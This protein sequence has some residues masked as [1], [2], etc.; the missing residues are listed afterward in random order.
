[1]NIMSNKNL[2]LVPNAQKWV[3]YYA[4]QAEQSKRIY[5]ERENIHENNSKEKTTP[6][7][8]VTWMV[9]PSKQAVRQA[10]NEDKR[11]KKRYK[12]EVD[13]L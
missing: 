2:K 8:P 12:R 4:A 7:P 6:P 5:E 3:D 13:I 10:E 11:C 9:S 1:M